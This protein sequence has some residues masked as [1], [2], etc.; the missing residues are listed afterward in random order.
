MGESTADHCLVCLLVANGSRASGTRRSREKLV[1]NVAEMGGAMDELNTL[2]T[3]VAAG[4]RVG[5]TV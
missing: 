2:V 1:T 4:V 3:T 5:T